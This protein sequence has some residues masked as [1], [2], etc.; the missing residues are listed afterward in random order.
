MLCDLALSFFHSVLKKEDKKWI[1][2]LHHSRMVSIKVKIKMNG[3]LI[4][5]CTSENSRQCGQTGTSYTKHYRLPMWEFEWWDMKCHSITRIMTI[6]VL[7]EDPCSDW[8]VICVGL[9]LLLALPLTW[10]CQ[11]IDNKWASFFFLMYAVVIM[12]NILGE[13][14]RDIIFLIE[15][16]EKSWK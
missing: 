9:R 11:T 1:G 13:L 16:Q 10:H 15:T 14:L 8:N 12:S 7:Q 3:K 6:Q 2:H 5:S 4:N